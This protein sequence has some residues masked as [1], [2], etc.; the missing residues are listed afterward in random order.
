MRK[1][2]CS[3][4]RT[5]G[6]RQRSAPAISE[7]FTLE[8]KRAIPC[9]GLALLAFGAERLDFSCAVF[10]GG[11]N[12]IANAPHLP[13]HLGSMGESVR[14]VVRENAGRMRAGDVFAINNPYHGGTHLPDVTV[15][16]PRYR[17]VVDGPVAGHVS[18]EIAGRRLHA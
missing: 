13:V 2:W 9:L 4:L 8:P 18:V 11:G 6:P 10:D 12:L 7:L 17:G 14:T 5:T 15:I 16:T 1:K 3:L